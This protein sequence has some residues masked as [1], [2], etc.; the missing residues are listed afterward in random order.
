[1]LLS[2][3]VVWWYIVIIVIIKK[4]TVKATHS[5][6]HASN[7]QRTRKTQNL[8]PQQQTQEGNGKLEI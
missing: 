4:N 2:L 5:E 3:L 6:E 8:G 1:M 7:R